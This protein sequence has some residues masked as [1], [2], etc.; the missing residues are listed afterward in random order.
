MSGYGSYVEIERHGISEVKLSHKSLVS[1]HH[2]LPHLASLG[3]ALPCAC[4]SRS[5]ALANTELLTLPPLLRKWNHPT[6]N[7]T[8]GPHKL[9]R[10][11]TKTKDTHDPTGLPV[12][13]QTCHHPVL[14]KFLRTSHHTGLQRHCRH[15]TL[16]RWSHYIADLQLP[17]MHRVAFC[18]HTTT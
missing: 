13:E 8:Y 16:Q 9:W 12:A 18:S 4:N 15:A 11:S 17:W 14:P 6:N 3:T 7:R 5:N 10:A 2:H 1:T